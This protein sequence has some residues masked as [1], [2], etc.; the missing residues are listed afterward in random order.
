MYY[1]LKMKD[2]PSGERPYEKLEKCGAEVLSNAELLAIVIRTGNRHETSVALAQRILA[3]GEAG[4][5]ISFLYDLSLEEL[6]A[7]K[8]IGRVKACPHSAKPGPTRAA[9]CA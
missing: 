1:N 7:A 6:R 4:R 2:M 5:G 8:G 3:M 9:G